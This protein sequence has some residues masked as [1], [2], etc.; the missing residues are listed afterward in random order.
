MEKRAAVRKLAGWQLEV[1]IREWVDTGQRRCTE[2][3]RGDRVEFQL[4][5]DGSGIEGKVGALVVLHRRRERISALKLCLGLENEHEVF[6]AESVG[7]TL[8]LE[9]LRREEREAVEAVSLWI[10]NTSAILATASNIPGP[11]HYLMDHFHSLLQQVKWHH[12]YM[13]I[14][15]RWVPGHEGAKGNEAA[16]VHQNLIFQQ[17]DEEAKGAAIQGSSP[18][19]SL[20]RCLQKSLPKSCS[21]TRKT[22]AKAL[23]V[24]HDTMFHCSPW[25]SNF[26]RVAKGDA[27]KVARRFRKMTAGLAKKHTSILVQLCT[28][29][30][31]LY[32]HLN[33][34]GKVASSDCPACRCDPETTFHYLLQCPAHQWDRPRQPKAARMQG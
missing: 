20:P 1:R 16:L 5:T 27:T 13:E 26:Q 18:Q 30:N 8:G 12:P 3:D 21:A 14:T 25:Y 2:A 29:H 31:Y 9:L 6:E 28:C 22:F 7:P 23:N 4:Y 19:A 32:K 34:I 10:D 17:A 11:S 33:C 24:L 15:V